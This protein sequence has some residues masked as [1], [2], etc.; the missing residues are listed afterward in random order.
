T[1]A[2]RAARAP[3]PTAA[4]VKL[5]L[6]AL[7][8]QS[9]GRDLQKIIDMAD[10]LGMTPLQRDSIEVI[11]ASYK[12]ARDSIY[13]DLASF[14]VELNGAYKGERA[15][16]LWHCAIATSI[17]ARFTAIRQVRGLLTPV[18]LRWLRVRGIAPSL[19]YSEAWLR[20]LTRGPLLPQ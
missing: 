12:A 18:Q 9:A 17:Q 6:L 11:A 2:A 15:R 20:R 13:G 8:Q 5:R 16:S 19:N 1:E 3:S 7:A 4:D 14:L 10:S